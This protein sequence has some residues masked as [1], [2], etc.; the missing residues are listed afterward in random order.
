MLLSN[1]TCSFLVDFTYF[2]IQNDSWRKFQL[3]KSLA[4]EG[5]PLN[6]FST[7]NL[8][9]LGNG[10][11]SRG[12]NTRDVVIDFYQKYY[13]AN[14]MKLVVYGKESLDTMEQWVTAKFSAVPNKEL[15]RPVFEA[16]PLRAEQLSKRLEAVPIR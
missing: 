2:F 7:G 3:F 11:Q 5:H 16:D 8:E 13:S 6:S 10:P 14:L 4:R 12:V 15:T 1:Y 9:T